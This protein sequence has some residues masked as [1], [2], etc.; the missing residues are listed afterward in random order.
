MTH[1]QEN[2][3]FDLGAGEINASLSLYGR[4]TGS[5]LRWYWGLGSETLPWRIAQIAIRLVIML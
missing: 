1:G 3:S 5:L 2:A 4:Q